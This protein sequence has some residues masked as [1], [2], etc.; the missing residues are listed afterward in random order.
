MFRDGKRCT[1]TLRIPVTKSVSPRSAS[2][3]SGE[4]EGEGEGEGDGDGEVQRN[5][6]GQGDVG[7]EN[8]GQG[9]IG[10]IASGFDCGN[11][12]GMETKGMGCAVEGE[13]RQGA[14]TDG[15]CSAECNGTRMLE[16]RFYHCEVPTTQCNHAAAFFLLLSLSRSASPLVSSF[17]HLPS[18][19]RR[20]LSLARR[21]A[22]R[23]AQG[24]AIEGIV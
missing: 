5:G 17:P 20:V 3:V 12:R 24:A 8:C 16:Q 14:S 9:G 21:A 2:D 13:P 15:R 1:T 7:V 10:Q 4:G 6:E 18:L 23:S 19:C 22:V 11:E